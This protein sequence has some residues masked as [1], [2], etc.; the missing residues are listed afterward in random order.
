MADWEEGW[1]ELKK[2]WCCYHEEIG[3]TTTTTTSTR[4][5][6][7]RTQTTSTSTQTITL[8][9]TTTVTTSTRTSTTTPLYECMVDLEDW[10]FR[11]SAY[12]QKWCCEMQ[13][14]GCAPTSTTT[15]TTKPDCWRSQPGE[16]VDWSPFRRQW[17]CKHEE[18]AC[19]TTTS[20]VTSTSTSTQTDT[21]TTTTTTTETR[22]LTNTSTTTTSSF[23]YACDRGLS[24]GI[25]TWDEGKKAWCC[26]HQ[27][28]GCTTTT[29]T[30]TSTTTTATA[31]TSTRTVTFTTTSTSVTT[32]STSST[33][34]ITTTTV[35][36]TT[37]STTTSSITTTLPPFDCQIDFEDLEDCWSDRKKDYC[38]NHGHVQCPAEVLLALA[39]ALTGQQP[40]RCH[41]GTPKPNMTWDWES[42]WVL[43]GD[44]RTYQCDQDLEKW[45][46]AW[47]DSKKEYCCKQELKWCPKGFR[48][49]LGWTDAKTEWCCDNENLGCDFTTSPA[50]ATS[51]PEPTPQATTSTTE[52]VPGAA[53]FDCQ[54]D[55]GQ[56]QT[57]W[58]E[59]KILWCCQNEQLGCPGSEGAGQPPPEE[60]EA[61]EAEAGGDEA[62]DEEL[63]FIITQSYDCS[64]D[65]DNWES[66]WSEDKKEWCCEHESFGCPPPGVDLI[67]D[68]DQK[69]RLSARA[70]AS[71]PAETS[72]ALGLVA[73]V[74]AAS[75]AG[76]TALGLGALRRQRRAA[77]SAYE[78]VGPPWVD[79]VEAPYS[80]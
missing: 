59:D 11:W 43:E 46:T 21:N 4:T 62:S 48:R 42:G 1:S 16:E 74:A 24:T 35:T 8:T 65:R 32:T 38:C 77:A 39:P 80:E 26:R 37:T 40:Y 19:T 6:T 60:G 53:A 18:V 13:Q 67:G 73:L 52:G 64:A 61:S 66:D 75:L 3:C 29:T 51:A 30:T 31:T 72:A 57:G 79:L 20:T 55:L 45:A 14:L 69:L 41:K 44:T 76:A 7:T 2:S 34:T 10:R 9:N 54:E 58:S 5:R 50:P 78:S 22:T 63:P 27:K 23:E 47:S 71:G 15:T 56:S 12:K 70:S 49:E 28:V 25:D 17:C 36:N 68:W 33:G